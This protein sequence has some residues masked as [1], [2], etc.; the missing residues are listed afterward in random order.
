MNGRKRHTVTCDAIDGIGI[1]CDSA[2]RGV[3]AK[4]G[5]GRTC[6]SYIA[7]ATGGERGGGNEG[8][9]EGEEGCGREGKHFELDE[10]TEKTQS[11]FDVGLYADSRKIQR[12]CSQCRYRW[13]SSKL[14]D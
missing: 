4:G 10:T 8:W 11:E 5:T 6:T 13:K 3:V 1:G 12:R 7:V 2:S 9:K 14:S